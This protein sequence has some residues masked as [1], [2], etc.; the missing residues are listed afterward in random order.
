LL[1][2]CARD[3]LAPLALDAYP[4]AFLDFK[5]TLLMLVDTQQQ[6]PQQQQQQPPQGPQQH[7][8]EWSLEARQRLAEALYHSMVLQMGEPT[9]RTRRRACWPVAG[10]LHVPGKVAYSLC[11]AL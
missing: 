5:K 1:A 9:G 2:A 8:Q 10:K 11:F 4:E 3:E 7:Q 6:R